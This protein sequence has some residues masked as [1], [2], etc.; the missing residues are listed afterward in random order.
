[1]IEG[2]QLARFRFIEAV[3]MIHGMIRRVHIERAFWVQPA[4]ASRI[5][6]EYKE[7][8]PGALTCTRSAKYGAGAVNLPTPGFQPVFLNVA[9]QEFLAAAELMAGQEIIKVEQVI[10]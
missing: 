3:L 4:A 1:M 10:N 6:T 7:A 9:P 8:V 5:I 2:K